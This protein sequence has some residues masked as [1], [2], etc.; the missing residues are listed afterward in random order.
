MCRCVFCRCQKTSVAPLR[1]EAARKKSEEIRR[2]LAES[3]ENPNPKVK[4]K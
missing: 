2:L 3:R 1:G 4:V